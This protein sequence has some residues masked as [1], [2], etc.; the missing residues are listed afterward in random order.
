MGP[1]KILG[2]GPAGLTAA[3]V[4]A[5]AGKPVVVYE[6]GSNVG[7]RH[8]G[9]LEAFENWT[10]I[11]DVWDEFSGWGLVRNFSSTPLYTLT[12]YGPDFQN[13]GRVEDDHHPLYYWTRRGSMEG[14]VD[15]GLLAQALAAGVQIDFNHRARPEE[16]NI[17][18]SGLSRPS[19]FAV[20]Y[21][22]KTH[23]PDGAYVCLDD[24]LSPQ[25]Y[26]YLVLWQGTGTI[27]ATAPVRQRGMQ[28][29]LARVVTGFRSH[30]EFDFEEPEY[31]SASISFGLPRRTG[32][33]G[34]LY[35]GEAGGFQ[36]LLAGFG[37]RISMTSGYLAARSIL[38]NRNFDELW[39]ARIWPSQQAT[40]V[41]RW[42][43]ELFGN[44]GYSLL[45]RYSRLYQGKGRLL[46]HRH[47]HP[48]WYTPFLWPLA[49][50]SM[51]RK[52]KINHVN[53]FSG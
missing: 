13:I 43:F 44:R 12:V 42:A 17:V 1:I 52:Y 15:H 21:N 45:V 35:I 48:R 4:L 10:S 23:A 9:D 18:A 53:G 2:A 41:N 49:Y 39:R 51:N 3:I 14:S 22:F 6:R 32:R 8:H 36:D 28:K 29:N 19:A 31:F 7:G 33:D 27:A 40:T 30:I 26:S 47:Y 50:R 11:E 25:C 20:G 38:E 24:T 37:M 5:R 34:I 16:V 46:L